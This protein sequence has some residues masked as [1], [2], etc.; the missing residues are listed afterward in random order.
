MI[1]ERRGFSV[2]CDEC[3]EDYGTDYTVMFDDADSARRNIESSG[4]TVTAGRVLCSGC[5]ASATCAL[6]GH[7][8]D[9]WIPVDTEV[10]QGRIRYCEVCNHEDTDPLRIRLSELPPLDVTEP[11]ARW[12]K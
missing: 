9:E 5:A 10:Y 2:T 6:L 1:T 3:R 4:W 12:P 7:H 8:W 11:E